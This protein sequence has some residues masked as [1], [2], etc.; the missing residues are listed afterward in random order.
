MWRKL[1][2]ACILGA[3]I[4]QSAIVTAASPASGRDTS[5]R[6]I[7]SP[8]AADARRIALVIGNADYAN[9]RL[10]SPVNDA[11]AMEKMLAAHGFDVIRH[12][13]LTQEQM[14]AA[15]AAFRD[16]LDEGGTALFYFAGHGFQVAGSPRLA[17]TDADIRSPRTLVANSID[18]KDVLDSM[19]AARPGKANLVILDSCLDNPFGATELDAFAAP[20]DTLISYAAAPGQQAFDGR[21]HGVFTGE[22][23][24]AMT[25]PGISIEKALQHTAISVRQLSHQKQ[26]PQVLT[27]RTADIRFGTGPLE[28]FVPLRVPASH[29]DVIEALRPRAILPKDSAEQYEL[30]FWDSIKDSTHVADYEAYLQAYPKGRFAALAKARIERLK[31]AAPKGE[32]PATKAPERPKPPP[33]AERPKPAP[34]EPREAPVEAKPEPVEKEA[35]KQAAPAPAPAAPPPAA[36][37]SGGGGAEIRDCP[38]C[39][40]LVSLPGGTFTMGSNTGDPSERPAHR[41]TI[42]VPFA[43]GKYEVTAEQWN[44]CVETGG[45]PKI[46]ANNGNAPG[47]P[48]RD[49]SW[50]DAQQYVKWLTKTTGKPYR[51]P[52][53][54]EWEY[55]ARAGTSSR[56]WWGEQMRPGNAN[57]KECG[58]PWSQDAP[59]NV[60]SFAPNPFGLH[61][62][63]GSVWEWVSDCWHPSFKGAPD[64][65]R[66]WDTPNCRD[67]VIRGGSW[68]D[69]A[70]YM[71]ATTRFKYSASVRYSQ[72][73]FRVV[74]ELK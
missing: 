65:G 48:I 71:P 5:G 3:V 73:G 68:R 74:R 56:F 20:E 62:V 72:N 21:L 6:A 19:S 18:L 35:P 53:E 57:C 16:R 23:I 7:P 29:A 54:A 10:A 13:N 26:S 2:L 46:S 70:S 4:G 22:L 49:V 31:A 28:A 66:P 37:S 15:L 30:A 8:P 11:R 45:C 33:K 25:V 44:A 34:K 43:I 63:V 1:L 61:D 9:E 64:D 59:A 47:T 12:E 40:V 27:S 38:A 50:D 55:A 67:R 58:D 41:V 51:L 42:G 17:A 39:P 14:N 32:P 60:G 52:T 24:K 69:G 36:R